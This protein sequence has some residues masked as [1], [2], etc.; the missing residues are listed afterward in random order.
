MDRE[1]NKDDIN[2][3]LNKGDPSIVLKILFENLYVIRN[4]IFHGSATYNGN[5]NRDT[6]KCG[7][8]ILQDLVPL[9]IEIMI[10]NL[11]QDWGSVTFDPD[12]PE[13][14]RY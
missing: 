4:Q 3:A 11:A 13:G 9:F 12:G 6:V 7:A 2:K 1:K 5:N 8:K 14:L 10:K